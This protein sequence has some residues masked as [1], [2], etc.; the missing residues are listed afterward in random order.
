MALPILRFQRGLIIFLLLPQTREDE[1]T[2]ILSCHRQLGSLFQATLIYVGR[3][4]RDGVVTFSTSPDCLFDVLNR[5]GY[6]LRVYEFC[7]I[8][9]TAGFYSISSV[10][11]SVAIF[12]FSR[13]QIKIV[14]PNT[15][16]GKLVRVETDSNDRK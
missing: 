12:T 13:E 8:F 2:F 10:H 4:T 16:Q 9:K 3:P 1:G 6:L 14:S 5:P 15:C 11:K 7:Y